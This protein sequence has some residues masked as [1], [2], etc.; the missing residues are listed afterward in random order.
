MSIESLLINRKKV[1]V[2]LLTPYLTFFSLATY[3]LIDNSS[4]VPPAFLI[5][6]STVLEIF[7]ALIVNALS[8]CADPINFNAEVYTF[9]PSSFSYESNIA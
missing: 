2:N 4:T 1:S 8:N 3:P 9:C 7:S 6:S 5:F